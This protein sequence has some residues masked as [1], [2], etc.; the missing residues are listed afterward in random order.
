MLGGIETLKSMGAEYRAVDR[1]S[2]L[3][4]EH[5]NI[6]LTRARLDAL[7]GA[8]MGAFSMAAPL[9]ILGTGAI[10][11]LR[12]EI[13]LGAMLGLTALAGGFLGPLTALVGTTFKL[14]LLG[15]YLERIE[16]VLETDIEQ[17]DVQTQPAHTLQGNIEAHRVSFR[18]GVSCEPAVRDVS[19]QIG[20]GQFV[21][22][23]GP[24]GAGKS[25]LAKLLVGLY[26][27]SE[28]QI[29]YDGV[30]LRGIDLPSL[31]QQLGVV[32]QQPALFGMSVRDNITLGK[33]GVSLD[34]VMFAARQAYIHEDIMAL[35]MGYDTILA[36]GGGSLS[37][38]QRQRVALAR[39]L[40][41]TP[42]ILL[43][44]EATSALDTITEH[45]VQQSMSQ[46]RCTRIVVAHRLSTVMNA[47]LILVMDKGRIV[48]W[49]THGQ[50]LHRGGAYRR[51]CEGQ[52]TS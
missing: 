36:D 17:A 38:G 22:I 15:S 40:V 5:L 1:W 49:G 25:T 6:S 10:L 2:N 30:D 19:V 46:L 31:R 44:D 51:L 21:A 7:V 45:A 41:G 47:D 8:I 11:V 14:Q 20:A 26:T 4:T 24:S 18:Y 16:D 35:P 39:A 13:T 32:T 23:V 42:G 12:G 50:L 9:L 37:G 28:G 43:L 34:A 52:L 48:E 27:P 33:P 3:F 29:A